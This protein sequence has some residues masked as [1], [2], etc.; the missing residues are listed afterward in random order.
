MISAVAWLPKGAAKPMPTRLEPTEEELEAMREEQGDEEDEDDGDGNADD[1]EGQSSDDDEEIGEEATEQ[2]AVARAKAAAAAIKSS[3]G[4]GGG[5]GREAGAGG[6]S[7]GP[8]GGWDVCCVSVRSAWLGGCYGMGRLR[9]S[10]LNIHEFVLAPEEECLNVCYKLSLTACFPCA[11]EGQGYT[12]LSL[13][14]QVTPFHKHRSC[15]V[16]L[17]LSSPAGIGPNT[18]MVDSSCGHYCEPCFSMT[19]S[20]HLY[21]EHPQRGKRTSRTQTLLWGLGSYGILL[22]REVALFSIPVITGCFVYPSPC[23]VPLP[24]PF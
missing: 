20:F 21:F 23:Q 5:R 9:G 12:S 16:W 4:G 1:G 17:F 2:G 24:P 6:A 11:W 22:A 8:S 19:H 18:V 7:E 10:N 14:I 13:S 3:G 15:C